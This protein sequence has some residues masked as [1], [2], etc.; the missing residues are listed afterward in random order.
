MMIERVVRGALSAA[1]T[2]CA[3]TSATPASLRPVVVAG[4]DAPGGGRFERFTVEALPT[5]APINA[6]GQVAFFASL[7]RGKADEGLF[8]A[9]IASGSPR[10]TALVIEGDRIPGVGSVS[11]FGRHPIPALNAAGTVAF[12]ASVSGGKTVEGIFTAAGREKPRAVAVAGAPAPGLPNATFASL[13]AP[14]LNDRGDVAFLATVRRGRETFDA[15]YLRSDGQV[16]KV[17]GQGDPAPAGGTFAGF[18]PPA[19]NNKRAVAFGAVI[20]GR[21][22]PGGLFLAADGQIR[23]LVGAGQDTPLGGIFAKFSERIGLDDEGRVAFNSLLKGAS[24]AAAVFAVDGGGVRKVAAI[25]DEAPGGG[26]FSYLGLWPIL[27]AGG[28]MAFAASVDGGPQ[29]VAIFAAGP[30]G[31]ERLGGVG[32]TL[33]GAGRIETLTLYPA[34]SLSPTGKAT[35]AV[36]PTATGLGPAAIVVVE[37]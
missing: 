16:R 22:V 6:R 17:V 26:T 24:S 31:I 29:P 21:A 1:L 23:M 19:L 33:P 28:T 35:F 30:G 18:G 11:G 13:D 32:D 5:V 9:S 2:L 25:G 12:A 20:E 7:L 4:Q 27:G 14:V 15:V 10:V 8:I 36:A 3:A 34:V 37:P